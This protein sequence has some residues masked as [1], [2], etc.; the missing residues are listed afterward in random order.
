MDKALKKQTD[1][2]SGLSQR[3]KQNYRQKRKIRQKAA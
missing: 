2:G 1:P 3:R